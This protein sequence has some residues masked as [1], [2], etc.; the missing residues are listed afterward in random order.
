MERSTLQGLI[1]PSNTLQL[2]WSWLSLNLS[3]GLL[4]LDDA[5]DWFDCILLAGEAG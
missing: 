1:L 3:G 2:S 4:I 5:L